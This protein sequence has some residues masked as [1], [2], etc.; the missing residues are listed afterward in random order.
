MLLVVEPLHGKTRLSHFFARNLVWPAFWPMGQLL[1]GQ[2]RRCATSC[3]AI[4]LLAG[5]AAACRGAAPAGQRAASQAIPRGG[6]LVASVRTDPKSFN[7]HAGSDSTTVT[8]SSLLHAKLVRI[9]HAT[10]AVEPM[11]A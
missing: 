6:E 7:R 8:V 1:T 2:L 4:A 11:L 9:N 10:Q 5:A 3:A